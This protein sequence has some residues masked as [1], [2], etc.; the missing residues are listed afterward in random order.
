MVAQKRTYAR[1]LSTRLWRGGGC[2]V[3][4]C[5]RPVGGKCRWFGN[6]LVP[7]P[8]PRSMAGFFFAPP[9][10]ALLLEG[11][12]SPLAAT[13]ATPGDA[14]EATALDGDSTGFCS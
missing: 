11:G 9:L 8:R 12:G 13:P 10:A 4:A 7:P 5:H 14:A 6:R 2:R 1:R 3:F